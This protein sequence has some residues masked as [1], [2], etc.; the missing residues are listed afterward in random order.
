MPMANFFVDESI[1]ER[2]DFI[3]VAA[4][5]AEDEV[6]ALVENA[7]TKC[8]FDP[9]CDEFKSSMKM[10]GNPAARR[11][12]DCLQGILSRC[13]IAIAVCPIAERD[14][15]VALTGELIAAIEPKNL[16]TPCVVHFDEGMKRAPLVLPEGVS[17]LHGC[18]SKHVAGIQVADCAAYIVS[19][20]LLAELGVF[21]KTV[22]A[23]T[24][25]PDDDGEIELAW[26]LWAHIRYALSGGI[27]IGGYDDD[28]MC[29]PMMHP[30][31]LLIA[32][33]CSEDVKRAAEKRLSSVWLGCIH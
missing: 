33:S 23:H 8:G 20:M 11:L 30:F 9:V 2:G 21:N 17:A 3:V 19:M 6:Q 1:H 15:I 27:P 12:R 10:A 29:E 26:T 14:R 18:N 25:Y 16:T 22:P 4:V 24:V 28:G 5:R 7:L 13:Q 31:G 32:N